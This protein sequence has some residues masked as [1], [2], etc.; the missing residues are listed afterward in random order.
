MGE[1]NPL[2]P[3]THKPRAGRCLFP[4]HRTFNYWPVFHRQ[5]ASKKPGWLMNVGM[6]TQGCMTLWENSAHIKKHER[7]ASKRISQ[8]T[9][10][11]RRSAVTWC[12]IF[13]KYLL[14]KL[15]QIYICATAKISTFIAKKR[16]NRS[17]ICRMNTT[18]DER[19]G[20]RNRL[21][22]RKGVQPKSWP[23]DLEFDLE[24]RKGN[25]YILYYVS[26]RHHFPQMSS[27]VKTP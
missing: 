21:V 18:W 10:D 27:S 9:D 13:T 2:S 8:I 20:I 15:S 23:C 22:K 3:V 16:L 12:W 7:C 17:L 14:D 11:E 4:A 1:P 6:N 25:T 5:G 24:K 26:I 19:D